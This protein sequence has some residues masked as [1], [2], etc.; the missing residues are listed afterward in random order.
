MNKIF[1]KQIKMLKNLEVSISKFDSQ[2]AEENTLFMDFIK[3]FLELKPGQL[4][5]PAD[6]L[7]HEYL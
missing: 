4:I 3:Q 6:A 7:T 2:N 5:S 1:E